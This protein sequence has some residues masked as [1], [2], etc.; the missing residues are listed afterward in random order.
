[1]LFVKPKDFIFK[2]LVLFLRII[3]F[4]ISKIIIFKFARLETSRLGGLMRTID[5]FMMEEKITNSSTKK[6]YIYF[7]ELPIC[8]F[9]LKDLIEKEIKKLN[10]HTYFFNESKFSK[11]LFSGFFRFPFGKKNFEKKISDTSFVENE[12]IYRFFNYNYIKKPQLN[13][14]AKELEKGNQFLYNLNLREKK[15]W[16][17]IH[18]RDSNYL[19][20]LSKHENFQ[21]FNFEYQNYRD[22]DVN[23]LIG[24]TKLLLE[25]NFYVFRMGRIQSNKM[26]FKHSNFIDYAFTD[27]K[28]DF[29][30]IFLL[31]N[32][33]AYLG[34]D[35]GIGDI[36]FVSGKPRFLMNYSLTLLLHL[37]HEGDKMSR[38]N[39]YPFIFKHL[40]D[41][42]TQK[43]LSLKKIL[44]KGLLGVA[45]SNDF[46]KARVLTI[47]NSEEEILDITAEMTNY[48]ENKK[49]NTQEDFEIQKKF[50]DIYYANTSYKRYEDIPARVCGKFLS[51][52]LYILE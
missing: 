34:S 14:N 47:E 50:W 32:C 42:K 24:S 43:K 15:Q 38:K 7:R 26:D 13:L 36:P 4:S 25:K 2:I 52:N 18:N 49:I 46:K 16:I 28:S 23:N 21:H 12:Q 39:N 20:G 48:L 51:K 3:I 33:A 41:E 45:K 11:Y 30:D 22:S 37:H 8:N 19:K 29:N 17:C 1:M 35:S 44:N 5:I 27:N 31:S 10:K 40:Y 6:I 9:L